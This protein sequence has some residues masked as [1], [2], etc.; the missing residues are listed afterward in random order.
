MVKL[1]GFNRLNS[2]SHKKWGGDWCVNI[3][4]DA[5]NE[6]EKDIANLPLGF[7]DKGKWLHFNGRPVIY[8]AS[9]D[10]L[11]SVALVSYY[12]PIGTKAWQLRESN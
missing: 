3:S 6:L 2:Y 5:I 8:N 7:E 10:E 11:G 9:L 1:L 4:L 12:S